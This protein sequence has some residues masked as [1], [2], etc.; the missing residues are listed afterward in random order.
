M[1]GKLHINYPID[2]EGTWRL[3]F[4]DAEAHKQKV[5]KRN[6]EQFIYYTKYLKKQA[7][8]RNKQFYHFSLSTEVKKALKRNIKQGITDTLW[9]QR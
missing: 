3:W 6:E 9:L 2:W 7:K 5:L 4:H 8:Y 1:D